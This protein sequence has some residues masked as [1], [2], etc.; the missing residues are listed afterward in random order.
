MEKNLQNN[1]V[2]EIPQILISTYFG[3]K[4]L[5]HFKTSFIFWNLPNEYPELAVK[6][7]KIFIN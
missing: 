5:D 7:I 6:P 4:L 3:Q 1:L 2:I